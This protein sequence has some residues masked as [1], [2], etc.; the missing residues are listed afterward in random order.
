MS[1]NVALKVLKLS[2]CKPFKFTYSYRQ[3]HIDD[4]KRL[5]TE[6]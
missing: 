2:K 1:K 6:Y 4:K 3:L 5:R